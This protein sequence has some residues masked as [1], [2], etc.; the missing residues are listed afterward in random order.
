[1]TNAAMN[2]C[3]GISKTITALVMLL[4]SAI[5]AA[6]SRPA[7]AQGQGDSG[8]KLAVATRVLNPFP[9]GVGSYWIYKGIAREGSGVDAKDADERKIR[10]RMTVERVLHREGATAVVVKGFPD[11]VD[12]SDNPPAKESMFVLTDDGGFYRISSEDGTLERKFTDPSVTIQGFLK[13]E[14]LWFQWPPA[15]GAQPGGGNCPDRSDDMYCWILF[16]VPRKI[17]LHGV[18]GAPSGWETGYTLMY[19]TNPDHTEVDIVSGVGVTGFEYHH[20]GTVAD[21]ELGLV[22]VHLTKQQ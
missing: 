6:Q 22:E 20:H 3:K 5:V 10:W 11:D 4:A 21:I 7:P 13:D 18:K 15:R 1:M 19:R 16:D 8:K 9:G 17:S 2:N 12:W 14:D